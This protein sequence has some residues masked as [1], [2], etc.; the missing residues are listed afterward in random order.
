MSKSRK[1]LSSGNSSKTNNSTSDVLSEE[2]NGDDPWET[3]KTTLGRPWKGSQS[4][5]K[6]CELIINLFVLD[7]QED[8]HE[9]KKKEIEMLVLHSLCHIVVML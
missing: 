8:D 6:K 4:M 5:P 3:S 2:I 9:L 7:G 1:K